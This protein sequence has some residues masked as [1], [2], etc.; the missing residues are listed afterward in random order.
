L[1]RLV[2][3]PEVPKVEEGYPGDT[4]PQTVEYALSDKNVKFIIGVAKP[5]GPVTI[6]LDYN[7]SKFNIF[8]A[9]AD[10]TF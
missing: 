2:L 1:L 8:T 10:V 6:F 4:K 3:P 5:I 9:G 7:I